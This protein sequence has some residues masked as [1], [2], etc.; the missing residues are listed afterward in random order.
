MRR[1]EAVGA[2]VPAADDHDVAALR[3]DDLRWLDRVP[4]AETVLLS[5]VI[6]SEMD[7]TKLSPWNRQIPWS[8]GAATEHNSIEFPAQSRR[9][10]I[11]AGVHARAEHDPFLLHQGEPAIQEPLLH[12]EFGNT[13]AQQAAN[14]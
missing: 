13:V 8:G 5:Q 4:F 7:S 1:P 2:S 11:D 12:L 14:P 6:D 9:R 10:E 3:R